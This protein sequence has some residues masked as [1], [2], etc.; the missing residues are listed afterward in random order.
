MNDISDVSDVEAADRISRRRS[1]L[2]LVQAVLFIAW[3]ANFFMGFAAEPMRTVD[4]VK[5]SAW[6]VW[7][8]ALL[9][10]LATGGGLLRRPDLRALLND[11][12]T[13]ANRAKACIA[14]F[15]A[16]MASGILIYFIDLF[17]PV[18]AR[19]AMHLLF[20]ITIAVALITFAV[21]ERR[22]PG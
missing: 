7:V 6:F 20:S 4:T 5:V 1:R 16:A 10:L 13:R 8:L 11:E 17:E 19:E 9:L 14:G 15:W 21:R 12:F 18:D 2:F 22:D 3:Q